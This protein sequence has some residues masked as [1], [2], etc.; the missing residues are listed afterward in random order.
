MKLFRLRSR[1]LGLALL[2]PGLCVAVA[3]PASSAPVARVAESYVVQADDVISVTVQ[4][5]PEFSVPSVIVPQQGVISLPVVKNLRVAGKTLSQIDAEITRGLKARLLRP[6]V[7]VRLEKPRPRPLSVL[8]TVKNAGIF[9]FKDGWRVSQV[10]AAAGGLNVP[11]DLAAVVVNRGSK[12]ILDAP[13][14]PILRDQT[15]PQNIA[16][17]VGDVLRFYERSARISVA[18]SVAKPGPFSV[19]IG[20]SIVE[21]VGLAGGP[22]EDAS[23]SRATLR[24]ANGRII[25]VD[26]YKALRL[27]DKTQNFRVQE[28]DSLVIPARQEKFAVYGAVLKP[29]QFPLP[30]GRVLRVADAISLAGGPTE[31]AALTRATIRKADGTSQTVNLY[32]VVVLGLQTGNLV[33]GPED[34]ISVPESRG[35]TVMGSVKTPG[36]YNFDTGAGRRLS[37]V[38]T[39]AGDLNVPPESAKISV[40]SLGADG[41]TVTT[42]E[43]SYFD[44][45]DPLKNPLIRDGD[46]VSIST[47]KRASVNISGEV[48]K[49]GAYEV[50]EGD[51]VPDLIAKAGGPT[52]ESALTQVSITRRSGEVLKVDTSQALRAGAP[53]M[54]LP[55]LEGDLVVVPVSTNRVLV[56]GAV[57]DQK[58]YAIAE[59][60]VFTVGDALSAAGGVN[61]N[62]KLKEIALLRRAP[63]AQP[64][65]PPQRLIVSL[66]QFKPGK[67]SIA[68]PVQTGDVLYVPQSGGGGNLFRNALSLAGAF[69]FF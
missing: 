34:S 13:L 46:V 30:D 35:V 6:E 14:L 32:E 54:K 43:V 25:A 50:S 65:D 37:D 51:S 11:D 22:T 28:G 55:L 58:S 23:L 56:V 2:C 9:E 17:K 29:G 47:I 1:A 20:S 64:N 10:I 24:R 8:G 18:G 3:A 67:L 59:D 57:K 4:K 41:K 53:K 16:L 42:N 68:S 19:P 33:L 36:N 31:K 26:L 12:I 21:A 69:R 44:L 45:S 5:H 60:R 49:P 15:S 63:N 62:A 40:T 61:T 52:G 39:R 7:S 27:G 38:L 48:V 66:D